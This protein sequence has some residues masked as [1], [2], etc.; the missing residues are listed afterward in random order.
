MST[1]ARSALETAARARWTLT[2][3][4]DERQRCLR[5]LADLLYA[6]QEEAAFPFPEMV[7][8][9]EVRLTQLLIDA[10]AAGF[11]PV[12]NKK[13]QPLHFG[14]RRL[15]ATELVEWAAGREG[16]ATYRELSGLAHANTTTLVRYREAIPSDEMP[17]LPGPAN[18][19][20]VTVTVPAFHAKAAIPLLF[21]V[22][23]TYIDAALTK[24]RLYGWPTS[25]VD[26]WRI[27]AG[28]QLVRLNMIARGS[29]DEG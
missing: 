18:P 22:W 8:Q 5:G 16:V 11:P 29:P 25:Y 28:R 3:D 24:I 1:L 17:I 6:F 7:K 10:E 15:G 26:A 20:G 14:E 12:R 21:I 4:I 19:E 27:E 13:G 2:E 9:G 23:Q